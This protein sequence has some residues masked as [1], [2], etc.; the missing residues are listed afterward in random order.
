MLSISVLN[1]TVKTSFDVANEM[2]PVVK[3]VDSSWIEIVSW[4]HGLEDIRESL[5]GLTK[6]FL[7]LGKQMDFVLGLP[8]SV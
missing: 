5:V 4:H 3:E 2:L 1:H 7:A 6:N 8:G